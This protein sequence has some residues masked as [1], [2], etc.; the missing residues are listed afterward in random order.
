MAREQ[1][2]MPM[3]R[4]LNLKTMS[5]NLPGALIER[6]RNIGFYEDLSTSSIVEKALL[7]LLDG[8]TDA[9]IALKLRASGATLRRP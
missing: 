6:V 4:D 1:E 8:L 7:L 9:E 5:I 2:P 3:A